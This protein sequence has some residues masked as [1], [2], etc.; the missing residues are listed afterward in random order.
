MFKGMLGR[1]NLRKSGKPGVGF[2]PKDGG[3]GCIEDV[4]D[5]LNYLQEVWKKE[6]PNLTIVKSEDE[7]RKFTSVA[8]LGCTFY[9]GNRFF[10]TAKKK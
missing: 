5:Q 7:V 2:D 4:V 6:N 9:Y 3:L 10:T 1:V 8:A